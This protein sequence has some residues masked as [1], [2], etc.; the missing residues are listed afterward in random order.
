M[1]DWTKAKDLLAKEGNSDAEVE[2]ALRESKTL[3]KA[4]KKKDYYKI[5]EIDKTADEEDIK[6][7]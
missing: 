4:A 7:A 1:R 5:L 3:L 2:R 6:K